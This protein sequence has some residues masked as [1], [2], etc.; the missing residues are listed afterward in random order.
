MKQ[1]FNHTFLF[2][3]A[4]AAALILGSVSCSREF[5]DADPL[6]IYEPKATFST[7]S[8]LKAAMEM[9]GIVPDESMAFHNA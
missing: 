5:L 6:S 9:T 1:H 2:A 3:C 8:G 4:G 7:E